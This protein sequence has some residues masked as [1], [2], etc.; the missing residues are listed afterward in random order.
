MKILVTG[1]SGRIGRA[2]WV[3]LARRHEVIGLDRAPASTTGVVADIGDAAAMHTVL[4]GVDAVVHTAALHAPQVGIAPE[5]EFERVNVAATR[6]LLAR[7]LDARVRSFVFTSTTALYGEGRGWVTEETVPQPRTVYHHSKLAAEALLRAAASS[8]HESALVP[9]PAP[10][11]VFI[12]SGATP[13][14]PDD[15]AALKAD[16]A[17]VIAQR[18]PALAQAVADRGWALPASIDRVYSPA[19]ALRELGWTP[20]FGFDEVLRHFD[21]E[22]SEL[23]PA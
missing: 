18:A 15:A 20:R 14:R 8:A 12:V 7:C 17:A 19:E 1:S 2:I 16:A 22:S 6:T 11:R 9:G 13:F 5:A 3:R 4:Q 23:L 10:Y 21:A